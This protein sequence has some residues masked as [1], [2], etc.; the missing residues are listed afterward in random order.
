MM[1]NA[2][3]ASY[4]WDNKVHAY[5]LPLLYGKVDNIDYQGVRYRYQFDLK[6]GNKIQRVY[7][8]A[9]FKNA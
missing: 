1:D 4:D 9:R 8:A 5:E 2:I 3:L 6:V 7:V